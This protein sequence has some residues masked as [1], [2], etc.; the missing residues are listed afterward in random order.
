MLNPYLALKGENVGEK[1]IDD[2][3]QK[4]I[5]KTFFGADIPRSRVAPVP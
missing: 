5:S 4:K 1:D 3:F 2:S